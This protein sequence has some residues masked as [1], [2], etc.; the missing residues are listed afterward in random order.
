LRG[1]AFFEKKVD[2]EMKRREHHMLKVQ[3]RTHKIWAVVALMILWIGGCAH[4]HPW[5]SLPDRSAPY[6]LAWEFLNETVS[7]RYS[8]FAVLDRDGGY[9]LTDWRT[10]KVGLLIGTPV[11]RTRLFVWV[12]NRS[13]VRIY[14]KVER[15]AYSLPL[16]RW[17]DETAEN[18]PVLLDVALDINSRLQRF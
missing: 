9:I 18:D 1:K 17:L 13:P 12:V 10:E 3:R 11:V 2:H 8:H 5:R 15:Q 6:D 4:E 7:T 14:L 16:G